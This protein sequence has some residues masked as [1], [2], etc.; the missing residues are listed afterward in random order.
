M[1]CSVYT[2][3][4]W[5]N[6]GLSKTCGLL[7]STSAQLFPGCSSVLH[8]MSLAMSHSMSLAIALCCMQWCCRSSPLTPLGCYISL[9]VLLVSSDE[10]LQGE[11]CDVWSCIGCVQHLD[12]INCS[13]RACSHSI[14]VC[15]MHVCMILHGRIDSV[16]PCRSRLTA[17]GHPHAVK[18]GLLSLGVSQHRL[19][20]YT[21]ACMSEVSL[22]VR[23]W[24]N[25]TT[26]LHD[27]VIHAL[28]AGCGAAAVE[29]EAITAQ[30]PGYRWAACSNVLAQCS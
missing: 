29:I 23:S 13:A 2:F 20:A 26:T 14:A 28:V 30:Q 8:A 6:L 10:H 11:M 4:G 9:I 3:P 25:L 21:C 22:A 15:M 1:P 27:F 19:R 5:W 12:A 17:R 24:Y 18:A 16:Y 7:N